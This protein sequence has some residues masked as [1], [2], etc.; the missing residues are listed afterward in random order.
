MVPQPGIYVP[1]EAQAAKGL[2]TRKAL[3][4]DRDGVIN[5]N[6]GYVCSPERTDWVPGI[7]DL[8][9]IARDTGYVLVVVTNQAGIARGL[10]TEAEFL[11]YTRWM[12][13][14]FEARGVPLTATYYCPHHPHAALD[15]YR[16]ECGCRK[17]APGM[18]LTAARQL[19]IDLQ[20]S[21]LVGD[22][23]SDIVAAK[24]AGVGLPLLFS[25][26]EEGEEIERFQ[27]VS[28]HSETRTVFFQVVDQLGKFGS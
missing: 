6:H 4:L 19:Q 18:I 10:Y 23:H 5:V 3:F 25:C 16:A 9:A 15:I 1:D 17:P 27:R 21:L 13:S 11:D 24:L 20:Q 7:F 26:D 22:K 2:A 28:N 8:C 12:H 14:E